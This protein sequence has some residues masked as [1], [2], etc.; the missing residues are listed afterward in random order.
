[1]KALVVNA[2][3]KPRKGCELT[4]FEKRT[5]RAIH[6]NRIYRNPVMEIK[7]VKE[8]C[9]KLDEVLIEVKACGICGS[10]VH[11]LP[12]AVDE[13]GYTIYAGM[14]KF[15]AVLGHEFS[16]EVVE[17]GREVKDLKVGD[18]VTSEEMVWCGKCN[19]CRNGFPNH[20]LDIDEI[21]FTID[22]AYAKYVA[23]PAKLCWKLDEIFEKCSND[24]LA[25][26]LGATVEPTCVAYNG[27]FIR[28]GG[29]LPGATVVIYGTGPIGLACISLVRAGGAAKI[30]AFETS[31]ERRELAKEMGA[32]RVYNP[33]ET[34][35][36]ETIMEL[37]QGEGADFSIEAAGV[38]NQTFPEMERSL[39]VNGKILQIGRAPKK[40]PIN[41]EVLMVGRGQIYGTLGHSGHKVFPSAIKMMGAGLLDNYKMITNRF[42]LEKAIEAIRKSSEKK[43]GKI[44]VKP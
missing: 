2:E 15:P 4:P 17:V 33:E 18:P 16:G 7:E 1:M 11:L 10:D 40:V 13:D 5:G 30:I 14:T 24:E 41:L 8:P 35:P 3:W 32:D 42:P 19:S 36:S 43:D 6:A 23:A 20:C 44:I 25:Y 37:T 38:P 34:V 39:A 26:E 29:F 22:G 9:I 31:A 27:I 28:A 12:Q 21:G